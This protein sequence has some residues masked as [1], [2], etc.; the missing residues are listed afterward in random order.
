MSDGSL[1]ML[2]NYF[3]ENIIIQYSICFVLYFMLFLT[4]PF[5][6][7]YHFF[8]FTFLIGIV[9]SLSQLEFF[10]GFLYVLE[11]TVVFIMLIMFFFF[12][13]KGSLSFKS[14]E[15]NYLWPLFFFIVYSIPTVYTEEESLLPISFQVAFLWDNYYE[16]LHQHLMNDFAGLFISYYMI[17]S[18]E[19]IIIGF[20]LFI[21]SIAAVSLYS[22]ISLSKRVSFNLILNFL[23]TYTKFYETLFLRLQTL[24]YQSSRTDG[25]QAATSKLN[26]DLSDIR[27]N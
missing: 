26:V 17:N 16:A 4:N 7:L 10:T 22:T 6:V 13:F 25:L 12:N 11:I 24:S 23:S 1:S 14:N 18:L 21:G 8:I 15:Y 3:I 2:T 5:S 20:I 27:S 9:I 19:L